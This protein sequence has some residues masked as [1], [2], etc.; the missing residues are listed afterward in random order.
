MYIL[1]IPIR[2]ILILDIGI[3]YKWKTQLE[4]LTKDEQR[5]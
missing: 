4:L 2:N 3:C 1:D 5:N